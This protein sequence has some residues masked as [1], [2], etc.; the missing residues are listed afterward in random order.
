M[1]VPMKK[2]SFLIYHREYIEFLKGIQELGVLHVIEKESGEI[3]DEET[4]INYQHINELSNAI[5]FLSKRIVNS[6][7]DEKEKDGLKILDELKKLQ[8][9]QESYQHELTQLR[10]EKSLLESWGDFSWELIEKLKKSGYRIEFFNCQSRNF[11]PDWEDSYTIFRINE[12]SGQVYF[13]IIGKSDEPIEIDAEN[14]RLPEVS[15]S[16]L[17]KSIGEVEGILKKTEDLFNDFAAQ[18]LELLKETKEK[19][20]AHLNFSRVILNT[21][22][23]AEDKLMFLEGW[24]PKEKQENINAYLKEQG[25]YY[26]VSKPDPDENVPIKLKNSKFSRLFEPVGEL[27]TMP[28]YKELD[29]T[30]FFAPFFMMFFGF[31][32][33]DMGYGLL[34]LIAAIILRFRVKPQLKPILTLGIFLGAATIFMGMLGGTLFGIN[35]IDSGYTITAKTLEALKNSGLPHNLIDQLSVLTNSHIEKQSN[36]LSQ[37]KSVIGEPA[38][39]MYR[40]QILRFVESDYTILNSFRFLMLNTDQ[41]MLLAFAVGFVQTIFG[42][43][44]KAANK[45]IQF[46]I[47]HALSTIGWIALILGGV[48]LYALKHFDVITPAQFK[49]TFIIIGAVTGFFIFF[50]NSPGKNPFLNLGLGVWDTYNMASGLLGDLLS[51]VRLFALGISSAVLGNVFNQLAFSLSP[52]IIVVG[53]LVTLIIL[54]FGHSLNLFMAAL[55]AF[56]HPLRL[57]FVEFYKNAGF[58]GGGKKYDPFRNAVNTQ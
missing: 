6:Q 4:R 3:Q 34:I 30:P 18:Y 58:A 15:L 26:V 51:Y 12:L 17:N 22:K 49:T 50:V 2:Y 35:L 55:G 23:E 46:G 47:V 52:D 19:I 36:F 1:I 25:V 20:S 39:R 33:G 9:D 11:N 27:Y 40:S 48:V 21:Q 42:M 13:I 31:C 24:V 7:P 43:G 45:A 28:D 53:Q 56:V 5:K 16:K 29:L 10:K 38:F 54:L 14:I 57:T 8:D 32:L 44:I 37:V 41:L